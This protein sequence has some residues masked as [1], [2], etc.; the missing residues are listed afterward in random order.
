MDQNVNRTGKRQ[1]HCQIRT[2]LISLHLGHVAWG[3][4]ATI[5]RFRFADR[6]ADYTFWE[7]NRILE[8]LFLN[9]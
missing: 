6:F 1:V 7:L 9:A 3:T 4:N 8:G 5:I 2:G